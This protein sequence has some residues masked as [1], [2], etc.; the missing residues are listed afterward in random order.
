MS[1]TGTVCRTSPYRCPEAA[2]SGRVAEVVQV[3]PLA[4]LRVRPPLPVVEVA[5]LRVAV[6]DLDGEVDECLIKVGSV[7]PIP[8]RC[9]NP[10]RDDVHT[11]LRGVSEHYG[12]QRLG[13]GP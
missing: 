7:P 3:P 13:I 10:S 9:A 1:L 8:Q 4:H 6:R 5:D 12:L 11:K 2:L